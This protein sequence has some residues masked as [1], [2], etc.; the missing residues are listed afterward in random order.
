MESKV[1]WKFKFL[2]ENSFKICVFL[3]FS[4]KKNKNYMY[5]KK[6]QYQMKEKEIL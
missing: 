6:N 3:I 1:I 5:L 4:A 2:A